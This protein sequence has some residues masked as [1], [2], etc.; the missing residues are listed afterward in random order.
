M[1]TPK[2]V[3]FVLGIALTFGLPVAK[4]FFGKVLPP[5]AWTAIEEMLRHLKDLPDTNERHAAAEDF[6]NKV[7]ETTSMPR[8][9]DKLP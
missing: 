4:I 5:A 3:D 8:A 7:R 2:W 9:G 1:T 6:K